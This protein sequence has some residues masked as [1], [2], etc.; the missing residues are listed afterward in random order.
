MQDY[1]KI[2]C[3]RLDNIGDLLMTLPAIRA[4]RFKFKNS[5][6]S[7]LCSSKV[8]KI[9]RLIKEIDEIIIFDAP[10][11]RATKKKIDSKTISDFAEKLKKK[12]FDLSIIFNVYSQS[13]LPA[14][15]LCCLAGIPERFAFCHENPYQLLTKWIPDP[16]PRKFIRHEV[17]RQLSLVKE[18][19]C[20][21]I[22]DNSVSFSKRAKNKVLKLLQ[23]SGVD[24]GKPFLIL[25]PGASEKIRIFSPS[26][27]ILAAKILSKEFQVVI[28]GLKNEVELVEKIAKETNLNFFSF[29]GSFNIEE[30]SALVSSASVLIANNSGPAHIAAAVN[31]PVVVL[32]AKTNFQHTPWNVRSRI[33]FFDVECKEC[34][35][36]I[37]AKKH[38]LYKKDVDPKEIVNAV[39]EVLLKNN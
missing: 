9:A 4:I 35:R 31:T 24:L 30:F 28:T 17:L 16:E 34:V 20:E 36:N 13:P 33:L 23:K 32:Y 12:N 5:K 7:L 38:S 11:I 19:G 15:V 14:A 25:H 39:N 26:K 10:W 22:Y 2:L 18:I 37:C 1:K 21:K 8:S 6:I 3:V 27:L 29:P